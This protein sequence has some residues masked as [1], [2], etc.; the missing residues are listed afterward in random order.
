MNNKDFS[1]IFGLLFHKNTVSGGNNDSNTTPSLVYQSRLNYKQ[2]PKT[3]LGYFDELQVL[4]D[5]GR[6][7]KSRIKPRK[8][9]S[10]TNV[11][12][13]TTKYTSIVVSTQDKTRKLNQTIQQYKPTTDYP[14]TP[15]NLDQVMFLIS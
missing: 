2:G 10:N 13:S 1:F 9:D 14:G 6:P 11:L 8:T 12:T 5:D 4:C 3:G 7:C 15:Y